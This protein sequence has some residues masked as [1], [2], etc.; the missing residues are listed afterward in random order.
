MVDRIAEEIVLAVLS[1]G[2]NEGGRFRHAACDVANADA[3]L[4]GMA[5]E[6]A[7][8]AEH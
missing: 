6:R 8:G 7:E 5:S 2:G 3:G 1:V 4:T